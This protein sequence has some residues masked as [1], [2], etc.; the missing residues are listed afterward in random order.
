MVYD[1]ANVLLKTY[2]KTELSVTTD[3]CSKLAIDFPLMLINIVNLQL[4]FFFFFGIETLIPSYHSLVPGRSSV[5][6]FINNLF[7]GWL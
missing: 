3:T 4:P 7:F 6:Q 2:Y 1:N 5:N